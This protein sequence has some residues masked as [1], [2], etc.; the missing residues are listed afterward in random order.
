MAEDDTKEVRYG[1]T[2]EDEGGL[3]AVE[4]TED[5]ELELKDKPG[6]ERAC[7]ELYIEI[8]KAFSN[9]WDRANSNMDYWDIYNCQLSPNQFYSGNSKIYVPICHDAINARVTRFKN[10]MFPMSGKHVEVTA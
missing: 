3:V 1:E 7:I 6:V 4:Q 2:D 8:E 10:Q 5:R 9:Q